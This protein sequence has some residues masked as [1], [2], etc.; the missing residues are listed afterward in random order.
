MWRSVLVSGWSRGQRQSF[1]TAISHSASVMTRLQA[2]MISS[3]GVTIAGVTTNSGEKGFGG[4][5]GGGYGREIGENGEKSNV[6][7]TCVII[8]LV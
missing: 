8:Y 2:Q 7:M 6:I 5:G 1:V 4:T 3:T